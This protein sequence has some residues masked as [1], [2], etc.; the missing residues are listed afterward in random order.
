MILHVE[1]EEGAR[2][3]SSG[4]VSLRNRQFGRAATLPA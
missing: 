2:E 1:E 3:Q 4:V